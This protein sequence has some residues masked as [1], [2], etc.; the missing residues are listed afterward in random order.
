MVDLLEEVTAEPAATPNQIPPVALQTTHAP[1]HLGPVFQLP[2]VVSGNGGPQAP[3]LNPTIQPSLT[4]A[5]P[6]TAPQHQP[7]Q[8]PPVFSGSAQAP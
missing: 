1:H 7:Y 5:R 3:Q 4:C 8:V 6:Q 2:P